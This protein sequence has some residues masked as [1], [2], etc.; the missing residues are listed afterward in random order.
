MK[1]SAQ[2]ATSSASGVLE[3]RAVIR[4]L[5]VI[6]GSPC[7]ALARDV[8]MVRQRSEL[9]WIDRDEAD[10]DALIPNCGLKSFGMSGRGRV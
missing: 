6:E 3:N 10:T 1:D 2:L 7:F 9:R 5:S 8:R 4:V